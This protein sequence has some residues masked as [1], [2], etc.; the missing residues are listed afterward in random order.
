MCLLFFV[1]KAK[2]IGCGVVSFGFCVL[3]FL[4]WFGFLFVC[5]FK[6][7]NKLNFLFFSL[8]GFSLLLRRWTDHSCYSIPPKSAGL[9]GQVTSLGVFTTIRMSKLVLA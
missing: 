4:F 1:R 5:F 6:C 8:A 7:G 3:F 2:A 9:V